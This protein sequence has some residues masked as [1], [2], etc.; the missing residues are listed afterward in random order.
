M[1]FLSLLIRLS[2]LILLSG[3]ISQVLALDQ[4]AVTA[5]KQFGNWFKNRMDSP[6]KIQDRFIKPANQESPVRTLDDSKQGTFSM[7]CINTDPG[8]LQEVLKV[9]LKPSE[10]RISICIAPTGPSGCL[11][12]TDF[13]SVSMVCTKGY[14][15]INNNY[16]KI[17]AQASGN[18]VTLV[19]QPIA[20][21]DGCV[22]ISTSPSPELIGAHISSEVASAM[23]LSIVSVKVDGLTARYYSG[24]EQTCS[25]TNE[26]GQTQTDTT[27]EMTSL[28]SNPYAIES[29][30]ED[31]LV[32]C[33][34]QRV[35]CKT[36]HSL[37]NSG[38]QNPPTTVTCSITRH[39]YDPPDQQK[40]YDNICEPSK[41]YYPDGYSESKPYCLSNPTTRWDYNSKF[42]MRCSSDGKKLTLEAWAF[43]EG[44]PCNGTANHPPANQIEAE[45][46]WVVNPNPVVI[47]KLSVN[48]RVG[49]DSVTSSDIGVSTDCYSTVYPLTVTYT[50]N[51]NSSLSACTFSF[52]VDHINVCNNFTFTI[53]RAPQEEVNNDCL[54]YENPP[55][56]TICQLE[57]E[58]WIDAYGAQYTVISNG[59][60]TGGL[61]VSTCKTTGTYGQVC[62]KWWSVERDYKCST[63][64]TTQNSNNAINSMKSNFSELLGSAN[65]N[66][67][68]GQYSWYLSSQCSDNPDRCKGMIDTSDNPSSNCRQTCLLSFPKNATAGD[69]TQ[70]EYVLVDCVESQGAYICPGDPEH[71]NATVEKQCGCLNTSSQPLAVLGGI[72]EALHKDRL[73]VQ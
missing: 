30:V 25:T 20:S 22:D 62:R 32:A 29:K 51:C 6:G 17:V 40:P 49:G 28:Y 72:Y 61:P 47:G 13:S 45:I 73:C 42:I 15:N 50:S 16:F 34:D 57:N 48:R 2:I 71:P 52:H 8:S 46:P 12:I 33:S 59:N 31:K 60:S 65:F 21:L 63:S 36:Y 53:T 18:S 55:T 38:S 43:W 24:S 4:G 14:K 56:G 27:S 37:V 70:K 64:N 54:T 11:G 66:K 67:N 35:E 23:N 9:T 69:V 7:S 26:S 5:G 1:A 19:S 44:A 10:Q 3:A 39:V 68:T 41:V 58:R